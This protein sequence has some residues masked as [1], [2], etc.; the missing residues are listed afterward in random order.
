M[1][2]TRPDFGL[3]LEVHIS[4][5]ATADGGRKQPLL[6]RSRPLCR[7]LDPA[8]EESFIGLMEVRLPA[9]LP[10]GSSADGELA[11]DV[12][13]SNRARKRLPLGSAC[14]LA[15]GRKVFGTATVFRVC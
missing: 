3:V 13:V 7:V 2:K 5:L 10:P 14:S 15:D 9:P 6:D 12:S 4:L 8:G 11:F 1:R